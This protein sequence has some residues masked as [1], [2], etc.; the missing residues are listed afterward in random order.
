LKLRL[1][2]RDGEPRQSANLYLAQDATWA[3]GLTLQRGLACLVTSSSSCTLV[4]DASGIDAIGEVD[5]AFEAGSLEIVEMGTVV[6]PPL[7]MH[8]QEGDCRA[9]VD[10]W[11]DSSWS[12]GAALSP[13]VGDTQVGAQIINVSKRT[14]YGVPVTALENVSNIVQHTE[15]GSAKPDLASTQDEG[16]SAG[17]TRSVVCIEDKCIEDFWENPIDEASAVLMTYE[18]HDHYAIADS[19]AAESEW[20]VTYPTRAHYGNEHVL[21]TNLVSLLVTDR[22]GQVYYDDTLYT[23]EMSPSFVSTLW[24]NHEQSVNLLNFGIKREQAEVSVSTGIFGL[25]EAYRIPNWGFEVLPEAGRARLGFEA[26]W[27]PDVQALV[28]ASDRRYQGARPS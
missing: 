23:P 27:P 26:S 12:P 1:L 4:E 9:I 25:E 7:A 16:T 24:L 10:R 13:P 19:L 5:F 11:N 14:L 22:S 2:D 28:A 21:A 18:V 6:D 17:E 15:L 3:G 8:V 20:V